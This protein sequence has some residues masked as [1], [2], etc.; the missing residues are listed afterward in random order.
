METILLNRPDIRPHEQ[1]AVEAALDC[2][3]RGDRGP[4][5]QLE[6]T[7][8]RVA[9]RTFAVAATSAG[10]ALE[11]AMMS[12]ELGSGDEV[13]CPAYGPTRVTS[14]VVRAGARPRF[15]DAH[16]VTGGYDTARIEAVIGDRTRAIVV[17]PTWFDPATLE[18]LASLSRRHELPLIEDAVESLGSAIGD[19]QAGRYGRVSVIGLGSESPACAAGGGVILTND[20][21]VAAHCREIL[22]EGRPTGQ[23]DPEDLAREGW[24]H[25]RVGLDGRLD[26]IR[27]AL[28][29]GVLER[30]EDTIEHRREMAAR[31]VARLGGESELQ[32]PA[33]APSARPSW[34]AFPI[35]LDERFVVED[36]DAIIAGLRRHE[37][38][39]S[40]GWSFAPDLPVAEIGG[41]N[42]DDW[43]IAARVASRTIHLPCHPGMAVEDVDLVCQ[44]LLL[45]MKQSVFSRQ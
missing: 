45:V 36:R 38:L 3:V 13:V 37:I 43:P 40:A 24:A 42:G 10:I 2:L 4:V 35:R 32:V 19:D 12:L 29:V 14:A 15:V 22:L 31:Y 9:G 20:E 25:R 33:P 26:V 1:Q 27:A 23:N 16:P 44:T 28:S 34:P 7:A 6:E 21:R 30:L 11:T 18:V 39:A 41:W 5:H 17:A 8:A